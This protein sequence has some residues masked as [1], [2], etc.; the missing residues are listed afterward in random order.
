MKLVTVFPGDVF[1]QDQ[2]LIG[3][4]N[5]LAANPPEGFTVLQH[6]CIEDL[7]SQISEHNDQLDLLEIVAH[8]NP[9]CLGV[10]DADTTLT[11]AQYLQEVKPTCQVY[12]SGCN[13]GTTGY[14]PNSDRPEL[15]DIATNLSSAT[16]CQV[17]G[18]MGYLNSGTIADGTVACSTDDWEEE[19]G[20]VYAGAKDDFGT[21]SFELK[22]K[23]T[24]VKHTTPLPRTMPL[25]VRH[26]PLE[27]EQ[28]TAL[29]AV[30]DRVV[31]TP[32]QNIKL[33]P[34]VAPDITV[35]YFGRIFDLLYNGRAVREKLTG[36]T[37]H[38]NMDA[39]TLALLHPLWTPTPVTK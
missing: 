1:H 16:P 13:T 24:F 22:P 7:C 27:Q 3:I 20:W 32:N 8:G 29:D 34:R 17:Y 18:S 21:N 14:D 33:N 10:L 6:T 19:I 37:W 2:F 12:L 36:N 5:T 25:L 31:T 11:L 28:E 4:Y 26:G 15:F 35:T 38:T 23:P 39:K 9:G 30:L